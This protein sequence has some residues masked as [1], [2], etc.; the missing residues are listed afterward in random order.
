MAGKLIRVVALFL[1]ASCP[2]ACGGELATDLVGTEVALQ[3]AVAATLTAEAAIS[4]V[5]MVSTQV[6]VAR[7]AAAT[8]TAEAP[9]PTLTPTP[10][11]V[12]E[13]MGSWDLGEGFR[14]L[15]QETK[16]DGQGDYGYHAWTPLLVGPD[17][18]VVEGFN[19][20]VDGFTT[21]ALDEFRQWLS[22][23]ID[24]PGST[25]WM[26]HTVTYAT[27]ELIS[28]LFYVDGYVM[29]AAHPFHY[30]HSLN[31]D[32]GT[33]QMLELGDLFLADADYL[34]VLSRYSLDD[35]ERQGVLE[36]EEGALPLPENFQ[37]WNIMAQGLLISFDAYT[38]APYAAGPQS[39]LIPYEVLRDVA[40][41]EGPLAQFLR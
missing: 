6:A 38:I 24:E 9:R 11:T 29:G 33:V 5:D 10:H 4:G 13:E 39:V 14:L 21:Y 15:M 3:Q 25:I 26:T 40:D 27:D 28:V 19:R 12:L 32:T 22:A 2:V 16:D 1:L 18:A 37:R 34:A 23:G 7:A 8:L 20:A 30:S 17:E 36:W 41:P 31:Y 35:L